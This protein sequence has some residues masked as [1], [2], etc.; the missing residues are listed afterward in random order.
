MGH[1]DVGPH[2]RPGLQRIY[3]EIAGRYELV[4]H[5]LTLGL[6]IHWRKR[7]ARLAARDGGRRWLDVCTG[8]GEMAENLFRLGRG[9]VL[10]TGADMSLPMLAQARRKAGLASAAL[11]AA[12]CGRLPFRGGA[13]DLVTIAFAT[14]NLNSQTGD[15]VH[16]FREFLRV[17]APGGRLVHLETSQPRPPW[18][19]ALAHGY[20]RMSVR[21]V[22]R[23]LTGSQAGYGYLA[24]SIPRFHT[25]GRL[26]EILHS[27]GAESVERHMLLGGIAAIHV[28]VKPG[29]PG[30]SR[31]HRPARDR[32]IADRAGR[33]GCARARGSA[34]RRGSVHRPP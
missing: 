24:R 3:A 27:S 30:H 15:L 32:P 11:V 4:N 22:G 29:A 33:R 8:T 1:P 28:A 25:A 19:R 12:E 2:F 14:R 34:P 18:L 26:D 21:A 6:D 9:S 20:V 23:L 7:A 13:F 10:I 17:L 5:L 31:P 16:Y